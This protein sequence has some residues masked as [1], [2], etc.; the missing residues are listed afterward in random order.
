MSKG[1]QRS[2]RMPRGPTILVVDDEVAIR[3]ILRKVLV[4][5]GYQFLGAS[6]GAEALELMSAQSCEMVILDPA[7]SDMDGFDLI[8]S[9][10]AGR[11]CRL[12]CS[13]VLM[14]SARR[15]EPL[16]SALMI[17]WRS[18]S[19]KESC[20]REYERPVRQEDRQICARVSFVFVS[21]EASPAGRA[22]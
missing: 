6:S 9:F 5:A 3:K 19:R 15:S 1:E 17:I 16:I 12:S 2:I 8:R 22:A 11:R 20:W 10:D 13:R 18:P 14:M 7:L 21:S 4:S